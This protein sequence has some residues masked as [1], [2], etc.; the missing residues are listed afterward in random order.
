M[1][2]IPFTYRLFLKDVEKCEYNKSPKLF[3]FSTQILKNSKYTD[4]V[5]YLDFKIYML[6]SG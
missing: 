4:I 1:I 6:G 5:I 2:N 3:S